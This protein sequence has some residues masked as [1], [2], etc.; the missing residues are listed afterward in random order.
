MQLAEPVRLKVTFGKY[1]QTAQGNINPIVPLAWSSID[2]P[3][4]LPARF[5]RSASAQGNINPIVPLAWQPLHAPHRLKGRLDYPAFTYASYG[6]FVE[7]VTVDKW[8]RQ[9]DLP[10]REWRRIAWQWFASQPPTGVGFFVIGGPADESERVACVPS[11]SRTAVEPDLL[12]TATVPVE[13]RIAV[14]PEL[15]RV[16]DVPDTTRI[17]MSNDF[18]DRPCHDT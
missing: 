17:V 3:R 10:V 12:R 7:V 6:T 9:L 16:V 4:R 1:P 18:R 5:N 8:W 11:S 14:V 13:D 2:E 15:L